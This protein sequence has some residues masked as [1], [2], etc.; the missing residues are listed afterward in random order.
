MTTARSDDQGGAVPT[1]SNVSSG[2]GGLYRAVVEGRFQ[3]VKYFLESGVR[4]SRRGGHEV[5]EGL[6]G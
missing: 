5:G 4:L 6:C 2:P 1:R 3:Q